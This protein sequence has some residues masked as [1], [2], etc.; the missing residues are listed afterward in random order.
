MIT[1]VKKK[2]CQNLD[3]EDI[4]HICHVYKQITLYAI[5]TTIFILY[6]KHVALSQ[7]GFNAPQNW[8]G[9]RV[10]C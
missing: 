5:I 1:D 7:G 8:N 9:F 3:L 10:L 6:S 4:H 2:K